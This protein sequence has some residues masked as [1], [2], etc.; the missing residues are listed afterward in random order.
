MMFFQNYEGAA[1]FYNQVVEEN[2]ITPGIRSKLGYTYFQLRKYEEA[3]NTLKEEI[4]FFP[5]NYEAYILLGFVYFKQNRFEDAAEVCK[6]YNKRFRSYIQEKAY[7]KGFRIPLQVRDKRLMSILK[8]IKMENPNIGLPNFILGLYHKSKENF[9]EARE[10]FR[11][12][13]KWGHDPISC[14]LQQIGIELRKEDWK[15]ALKE[16]GEALRLKGPQAEFYFIIGYIHYQLNDIENALLCFE[17]AIEMKPYLV[18]A[19]RNLAI[20]YDKQQEFEKASQLFER[21]LRISLYD[22]FEKYDLKYS[23]KNLELTKNLIDKMELEYTYALMSLG[24]YDYRDINETALFLLREGK[25]KDAVG[26]LRNF[27]EIDDTSPQINYNL[28]QLY[29]TSNKLSK[30]LKY[31]LR[32]VDLKPNFK[33]AYDLMGN[34]YF[35]MH[36]YERSVESYREVVAIHS[37]DAMGYYN[38]GCAYHGLK[39]Y[40]EAEDCWKKSIKYEKG[41]KE[42]KRSDE[43]SQ[44]ELAISLTVMRRPVSFRAHKSLGRLYIEKNLLEEAL[45]HF[46]KAAELEPSDPEPYYEIGKIFQ[47]QS[48]QDEK[49]IEK[50][51]S[52][53]ERY[54]YLGG[55]EEEEV[56]ERLTKL[57]EK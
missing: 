57:K 24:P 50:A 45:R 39:N 13:N 19:M 33:D 42:V 23:L 20:L 11:L 15:K 4:D 51:I 5:E 41:I 48:E 26:L 16:A 52:Y 56:N 44:D 14:I 30:A 29:N 6:A 7:S 21:F 37:K 10:N 46:K 31:A 17:Q 35:K 1:H 53:Y 3:I 9:S 2:P 49:L 22:V 38:L 8:E 25:L 27:L 12:A 28:G 40:D 34:I 18:E 36:D 55:K 47:A 43:V 54:L 32:A